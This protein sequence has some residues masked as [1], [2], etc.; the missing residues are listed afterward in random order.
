MLHKFRIEY[1]S[2]QFHPRRTTRRELGNIFS[3]L[4]P[5]DE[6]ITLF[7]NG[8]RSAVK[9]VS[10]TLSNPISL[11]AAAICPVVVTPGSIPKHLS[12]GNPNRRGYLGYNHLLWIMQG[13]PNL[14]DF[15]FYRKGTGRTD[16]GTL[17]AVN[18]LYLVGDPFRS[19][20][21][22]LSGRP[23]KQN[24]WL[25]QS[26]SQNICER[27]HHTEHTCSGSLT[28]EG[29]EKSGGRPGLWFLNLILVMPRRRA[30][31]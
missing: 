26:E 4:Y 1:C 22:P 21:L 23:C 28:I 10:K 8:G 7:N 30:N 3:T 31:A 15:G 9:E 2:T 17:S 16:T 6:L 25:Q 29:E 18:T 20:E 24:R 11:S 19:S 12:D 27:N 14:I 5:L 13:I